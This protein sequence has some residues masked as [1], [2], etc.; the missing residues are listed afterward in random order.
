MAGTIQE[1]P[2]THKPSNLQKQRNLK[3][4]PSH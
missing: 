4:P 3:P 1:N 2:A